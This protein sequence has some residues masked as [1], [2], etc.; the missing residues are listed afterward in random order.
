ML[1]LK[2]NIKTYFSRK[3]GFWFY[4]TLGWIMFI[5]VDY[6]INYEELRSLKGICFWVL[7]VSVGFLVSLLL[8]Y[9]YRKVY[10]IHKSILTLTLIIITSSFVAAGIWFG[11][12]FT[13]I[14][15]I[16]KMFFEEISYEIQSASGYIIFIWLLNHSWPYLIWSALYFGIKLWMDLVETRERSEKSVLLAQKA[17]LQ[18]L[19]YQLNPHFLYNTLNSIQA[20]VYDEPKQADI[21]ITEL[22]DFLRFSLQEKDKLFIALGDEVKIVEKYL[23]IERTRFPERLEYSVC[24]TEQAAKVEVIGFILQPF[25]E[26]AVKH[27]MKSS[28]KK[29]SVSVKGYVE[30][31]KLF[32]EVKN[33]GS[34]IEMGEK[35]GSSIQNVRE[36]LENVYPKKHKIHILKNSNTVYIIIEIDL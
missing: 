3:P 21:I 2:K 8:R 32:L 16:E 1:L 22:S 29:L 31:K 36:R 23:S 14:T 24:V 35:Y 12:S 33:N 26:N 6:F 27:G 4:Q 9:W 11:L 28:P 19:R 5:I 30:A 10:I 15:P 17:Q 7:T 20:L 34:W 25:V 13:V 18:M